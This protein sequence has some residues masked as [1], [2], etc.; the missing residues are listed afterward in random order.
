MIWIQPIA[1]LILAVAIPFAVNVCTTEATSSTAK[2]WIAVVASLVAGIATA[3][4]SGV[5]T[6]ET[7]VTWALAV[8]GGVQTA[9]TAFKSVGVT[10]EWLE[11]LKG[12]G[13]KNEGAGQP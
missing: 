2:R 8:V 5:P 3:F 6:P 4:I 9:Y 1:A 7:L 12:I 10:N 13:N 11:A